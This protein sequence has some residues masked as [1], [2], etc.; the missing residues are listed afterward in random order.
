MLVQCVGPRIRICGYRGNVLGKSIGKRG[1]SVFHG[2]SET[3][4]HIHNAS[5]VPWVVLIP[6]GTILLR[7]ITTLPLSIWQRK[8]IVKQQELRKLVQAVPPVTKLRLAA[9]MASRTDNSI[10]SS[11]SVAG[12]LV[13]GGSRSLTPE[14]ITLLAV[15]ETRK[16]Q[17]RLFAKYNVQMWKNFILPLVQ[18]PLWVTLSM[19]IRT[20]TEKRLLETNSGELLNS[21]VPPT[22]DLS[23][24]MDSLPMLVPLVLG[25][26]ALANVEYNGK[27]LTTTR[28]SNAGIILAPNDHSRASQAMT[29]I[30]NMSR[31]GCIF[32][33][34]ISSQAPL[35]LS[36]YWIS[37]Q[38]YSFTQN[39]VLNWLWPYER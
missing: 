21:I 4:I 32:M 28:A 30:L 34:G 13:N 37:S 14:Q 22:L 2:V 5:S 1:I 6:V 19:G 20:L 33:M 11:G 24:P 7:T 31:F 27:T 36:L 23:L 17:K 38:L 25:S 12:E 9:S 16:R 10:S 15:K 29:S 18:I 8:R 26:L 3:L 39:L 35:L